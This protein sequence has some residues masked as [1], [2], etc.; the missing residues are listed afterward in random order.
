MDELDD[1]G[2]IQVI[3]ALVIQ[4]FCRQQHQ[5]RAQPFTAGTDDVFTDLVD[6]QHIRGQLLTDQGIYRR[7]VGGAQV[8]C[9]GQAQDGGCRAVHAA[10]GEGSSRRLYA[11]D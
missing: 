11:V 4:R 6:Q 2:Q 10:S 1:C 8:L 5:H 3:A 7:H 9:V